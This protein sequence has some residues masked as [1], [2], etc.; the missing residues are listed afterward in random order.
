[1]LP[2]AILNEVS[3][4]MKFTPGQ[5]QEALKLSAGTYRHWKSALSPLSRRN[6]YSPCFTAGDLLALAIVKTLAEDL[7]I[8]ISVIK[9]VA[10]TLFAQCGDASWAALERSVMVIE[11]LR[12]RITLAPE[13]PSPHINGL[14]VVLP[15]RATIQALQDH[16]LL[17]HE[18]PQQETL[19][20]PPTAIAGTGRRG[21]AS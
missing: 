14:A 1:L 16:L 21:G 10:E 13:N 7:G 17:G 20:F 5:V 18:P 9:D 11:P 6:G 2:A 19:R 4:Q 8:K 12:S 15:L 3:R